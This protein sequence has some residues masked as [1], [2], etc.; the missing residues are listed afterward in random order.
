MHIHTYIHTYISKNAI[1]ISKKELIAQINTNGQ[2]IPKTSTL[3]SLTKI[4]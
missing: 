2:K 1:F 4:S 3:H